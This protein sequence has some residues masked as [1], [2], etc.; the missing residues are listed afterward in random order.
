[1]LAIKMDRRAELKGTGWK[2][3]REGVANRWKT[4]EFQRDSDIR[5]DRST[6]WLG[7]V[8]GYGNYLAWC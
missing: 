8:F 5:D 4:Y 6:E 7:Q 3:K 2:R 1:M